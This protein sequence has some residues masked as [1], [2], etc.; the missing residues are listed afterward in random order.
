MAKR[1]DQWTVAMSKVL[2][3]EGM[4]KL[5][6][7]RTE[8]EAGLRQGRFESVDDAMLWFSQQMYKGG[9]NKMANGGIIN[10]PVMGIGRSGQGY[11]IGESGA[12]R[13]TPM[14]GGS[15][16]PVIINVY[17]DVNEKTMDSF[18]RKVLDVLNR[19][20]SRRGL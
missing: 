5:G 6:T 17:G 15:S 12:E 18:E 4:M 19:S 11:L 7:I 10:E 1:V 20:N 16:S 9:I 14:S 13:V 3:T 2:Q 8:A